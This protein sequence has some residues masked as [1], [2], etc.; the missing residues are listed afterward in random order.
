MKEN[1]LRS[2][3]DIH[4]VWGE[5]NSRH[6]EIVDVISNRELTSLSQ[7]NFLCNRLGI[8]SFNL[9]AQKY[10][11]ELKLSLFEKESEAAADAYISSPHYVSGFLAFKE[12][13]IWAKEYLKQ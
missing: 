8:E 2:L 5:G 1:C 3:I 12:G 9:I 6:L 10:F 4:T 13:A 7:Y 11:D